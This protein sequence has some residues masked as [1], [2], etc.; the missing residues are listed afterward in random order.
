MLKNPGF[1]LRHALFAAKGAQK[2]L[3]NVIASGKDRGSVGFVAQANLDLGILHKLKK[4]NSLARHHL[5][6]AT[7][8]FDKTGAY[9]FLKRT[10][11][12]LDEIF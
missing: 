12:E 4:R 1:I 6:E 5:E 8:L 2:H 11:M 3:M 9:A 10:K 7:H